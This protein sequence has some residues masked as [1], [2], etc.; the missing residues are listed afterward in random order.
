MFPSH[1]RHAR[2]GWHSIV[3]FSNVSGT[4]GLAGYPITSLAN[5]ATYEKYKPDAATATIN[6]DAGSSVEI[7][8]LAM[9]QKG[10][11][12]VDIEASDDGVTYEGIC[13]YSTVDA[14]DMAQFDTTTARYWRITLTGSNI[15]VS[16]FKLGKVLEMQ[17][18]IYGGHT[19][20]N[21]APVTAVRPNLSQTGQLLG[22]SV[23]RKGYATSYEWS[24]L[25]ADWVRENITPFSDSHP[26]ANP[27]FMAWRPETSPNE[28]ILC[29]AK[30][31]LAPVNMGVK[32]FMSVSLQVEGFDNVS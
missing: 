12:D 11:A 4:A 24:N 28:V 1:D 25:K 26:K 22:S 16:V 2:I 27:F 14:T 3:T 9:M 32:D 18:A 29:V 10:I 8:Y 31:D 7:N 13:Y 15:S 17:R 6:I 23:I 19:P 20:A 30:N 5:I 21:I